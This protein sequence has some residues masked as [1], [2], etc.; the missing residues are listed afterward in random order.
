[1]R[2]IPVLTAIVVCVSLYLLVMQ[3]DALF[4]FATDG[5][6][7]SLEQLADPEAAQ[8]QADDAA[9]V[10]A[11]A[12]T[13]PAP[14]ETPVG[15]IARKSDARVIDSAVIL[16]GETRAA[17]QVEMR[18]ETGGQVISEP[19]RKGAFVEQD[20]VLCEIDPGTRLATLAEAEARL[21]EARTRAPEAS[22]RLSQAEAQLREAQLNQTAASRLSQ[23][24]F[25]SQTRLAATEA[26]VSTAQ[27]AVESARAGLEAAKT[28]VQS[29]ESAIAA[30][31]KEIDRL[32]ITA[33]FAGLLETDTAE[34]G[35]LM[36]AGSLCATVIQ[37]D[38]IILAGYIPETDIG[39]VEP[40]A[41]AGARLTGGRELRGRVTFLSRQADPATRTFLVEVEVPNP[42]LSVRD[43]QTAEILIQA[44]GKNAHLLPQS[45]LTLNDDGALGVR[46]VGDDNRVAFAPLTMVRDT[47]EGVWVNGLPDTANVITV[48]QEY[49]REGVLVSPTYKEA[50]Q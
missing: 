11:D 9:S 20:Q 26:Q 2:P 1:M 23:D 38:P 12:D 25:A 16:R 30:A 3:R 37:L 24:G 33:P 44:D 48:G 45:A 35:S 41:M 28:G 39:R 36:Q 17:R 21:A 47:T 29:A 49:V 15:V 32:T 4:A 31:K 50:D 8:A 34:I 13:T 46:I 40:G 27:A 43:G 22:A 42:D 10:P 14:T 19:L 18:A 7:P 5:T 6:V